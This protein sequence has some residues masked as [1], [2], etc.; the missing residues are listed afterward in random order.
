MM[1]VIHLFKNSAFPNILHPV[2]SETCLNFI[3]G[4][5][6]TKEVILSTYFTI[7]SIIHYLDGS[8]SVLR[9]DLTVVQP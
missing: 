4:V 2:S 6:P 9:Y 7:N 3:K 5:F 1:M 8:G